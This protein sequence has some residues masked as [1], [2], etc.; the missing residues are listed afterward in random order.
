MDQSFRNTW[1]VGEA[2]VYTGK[3]QDVWRRCGPYP[4]A[5]QSIVRA[6]EGLVIGTGHGLWQVPADPAARWVQLHDELLTEVMAVAR[7]A[8]GSVVAAGAYGISVS[9]EDDM[10]LPRWR[11]L[12][13]TR[14]PDER[15]T[16]ALCLDV[17]DVWL[18][19]TETGV[20]ISTNQGITWELSHL[21]GAPVRCIER[22]GDTWWAGTDT[23]GLWQSHDGHTWE[24]VDGPAASAFSVAVDGDDLL[25]GGFDGIW[26]R[27]AAGSWRR[28]GP[29]ALIRCLVVSGQTR[30][31][32]ADP[33][34]LWI[35]TDRCDSWQRT[36]PFLRVQALCAPLQGGKS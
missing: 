36:G 15:H 24:H 5:V 28:S 1:L 13:E 29:R 33:G 21:R 34:G 18:A 16:N 10:G 17:D 7:L 12:T 9:S 32:G 30:A 14:T 23:R 6:D 35:S 8:D 31:A 26:Q 27:D 25:V 22:L 3:P 19:G 11:S 4:F 2:G 20:L